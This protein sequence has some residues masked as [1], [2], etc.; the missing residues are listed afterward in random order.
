MWASSI[1]EDV[2]SDMSAI[3]RVDDVRALT[4]RRFFS[5]AERLPGYDGVIRRRAEVEI[6]EK[7][8]REAGGTTPVRGTRSSAP[9]TVSDAAFLAQMGN[10]PGWVER[11]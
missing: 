5:L 10:D 7:R 3:H 2:E 11:G 8:Q 1:I 4:A 9:Q 6:E